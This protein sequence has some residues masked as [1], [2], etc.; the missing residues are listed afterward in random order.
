LPLG[1]EAN[2]NQEPSV[3][4]FNLTLGMKDTLATLMSNKKKGDKEKENQWKIGER[5]R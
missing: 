5:R 2:N 1:G 3:S 4:N